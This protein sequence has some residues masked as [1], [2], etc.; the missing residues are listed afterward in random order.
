MNKRFWVLPFVCMIS[1]GI[2][3][4]FLFVTGSAQASITR[5][6]ESILEIPPT[7]TTPE[8]TTTI[9]EKLHGIR[10]LEPLA[11]TVGGDWDG[12]RVDHPRVITDTGGYRMWY[13]GRNPENPGYGWMVGLADSPDGLSWTKYAGNPLFGVGDPGEWDEMYR[14]QAAYLKEGGT[15]KMWFSG[16]ND[17]HWQT[18]YATSADGL[19]WSFYGS[20]P[21]LP[22]GP[23][24]TWDEGESD[25]PSVILEGGTYK[26][27]YHGCNADFSACNVGY[28]TSTDGID[29]NKVSEN[30]VLVPGEAG[31]WDQGW[32]A[33]PRV[34]KNGS[35][36]MMWYFSNDQ[37]GLAT[38]LDG[39]D[40]TKYSGNPVLSEGWDGAPIR[41]HD[42]MLENGTYKMWFRSGAGASE[43]IGYADSLDGITWNIHPDNPILSS[44]EAGVRIDVNYSHDWVQAFSRAGEAITV[45]VADGDGVK[46]LQVGV[47]GEWGDYGTW[48]Q[49]WNPQNP[50]LL[51]G[52]RITVEVAAATTTV[53]PIG[54]IDA[55]VDAETDTVSGTLHAPWFDPEG[56]TVLC[57]VWVENGPPGIEV[58]DV[59]PDGG[60]FSCDFGSQGW[61]ITPEQDIAVRYYEPDGDSVIGMFSA[62]WMRVNYGHDWVGGT[63]PA[64]H[65]FWITVTNDI[66]EVK[67]TAVVQSVPGGSWGGVDGFETTGGDWQPAQ[68]DIQPGDWVYFTS[69]DGYTNTIHVGQISTLVDADTDIVSGNLSADWLMPTPL[70]VRCEVWVPNGPPGIEVLDVSPDGGGFTCDFASVGWDVLP[71]QDIAVIYYEPDGDRVI[72][73][74]GAPWMRVNYGHDWAGGNY[75]AGHTVWITV[76]NDTGDIKATAEVLSYPG[77]GWG[78]D[79]FDT[80]WQDWAPS[81]PDI[82][83]G[84]WVYFT[85][86]DGYSNAIHVG[87][88]TG[89]VDVDTDS[90]SG[91]VFADWF[92]TTLAVECHPWGGPPGTPGKNSSAAADGTA[93]YFCQ[94]DPV[95]EWDILAGQDIGVMYI[96]P[97]GD[98][99][100]NPM[101]APAPYLRVNT[102]VDGNPAEGGNMDFYIEYRNEGEAIAENTVITATLQGMSYLGDTAPPGGILTGTLPNAEYVV[103]NLG[104]L[105]PDG[106]NH[107]FRL[108]TQVT[109][110]VSSTITSTVQI[111]TSTVYGDWDAGSK[112]GQ[113]SG[114]VGYNDTH[115]NVGKGAWTGDPTPGTDF[116]WAVN[117]C[118]N[119]STSSAGL[120][121]TDTLPISTTLVHWW[122]QHPGWV[123]VLK[124]DHNLVV[125][126]PSL[127]AGQCSEV[128]LQVHLDE[129][130]PI[131]AALVNTATIAS[132][133]DLETDDNQTTNT[134][135]VGPP[136]TNLEI[137]MDWNWGTL[138]PGGEIRYNIDY[139]NNGN[140]PVPGP[141]YITET[142]PAHTS[143]DSSWRNDESGQYPII[144]VEVTGE[145]VVWQIDGLENGFG[146]NFEVVLNI[147]GDALPG[148]QLVNRVE[149]TSLPDEDRYDDNTSEWTESVFE[150]GPNLRVRKVGDW[151][152]HGE[153]HNA[154]FNLIFENVGDTWLEQAT[155]TDTLPT[156]MI[157]DGDPSTDWGRVTNY[158]S[159]P[160]EGWFSI[161]FR[162]IHPNFRR[163]INFNTSI[164]GSDPLPYGQLFT[165]TAEAMLLPDDTNPDD[166]HGEVTLGTGPDLYVEKNLVAGDL[167]P[168]EVVTFGLRFGNRQPGHAWWWSLQGNAWMTDTL[169][170]G[171]EFISSQQRF[172]GWSNWCD[173]TPAQNGDLLTWQLWPIKAG[174]WNEIYLTV[175]IP[176]TADGRDTFTNWAEIASDLPDIDID[177]NEEDNASAYTWDILLP[178]FEV[179]K[180][181]ESS[182]IAGMPITYTLRVDNWGHRFGSNLTLI[183][184]LPDWMTYGGGGDAYNAGLITWD[185]PSLLSGSFTHE[186]F[187]GTLACTAGGLVNN[188][189]YRVSDSDQGV[190]SEYGPPVSFTILAPTIHPS[191]DTSHTTV[192]VGETVEFTST[193]TTDGTALSY[194]WDFGDGHIAVGDSASHAFDHPGRF[195]VTMTV[196]DGCGFSDTYDVEVT[197]NQK[198]FLPVVVR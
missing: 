109:E 100:L 31:E 87:E 127:S 114:H 50:N 158:T 67:A 37:I 107:R 136:H 41:G 174:E 66:D 132:A 103:W 129:S 198:V 185:I 120:T 144:P 68:P 78:T 63:Y 184:W 59:D 69:D 79:G 11:P 35:T 7:P 90:V 83:P 115:L 176:D 196:T 2:I 140:L 162:D 80:Q 19:A 157:L 134:V 122:E 108:F 34:I 113:W 10:T 42:V 110:P 4:L 183:D 53:D 96:E 178:Y 104:N 149:I 193:S 133:N 169:P 52:D 155:V 123:E 146:E 55:I 131:G 13:S 3:A 89:D 6:S 179:S 91:L 76:T 72:G 9:T 29:W 81:Q 18:G 171:F 121:L 165:N 161:T 98:R 145:V 194:A 38:S 82:Q 39:I 101:H 25:G 54:Q 141:F 84:D 181:Y 130:T 187:Y 75:P 46:A 170:A 172:C 28:A 151:H 15:Y 74:F 21:V 188:E 8:Q 30:P 139:H 180:E 36:Y 58:S 60:S 95:G 70:K 189:Y 23:S 173:N 61:D 164:P 195:T 138:V 85:T 102:W 175:R 106:I 17:Q 99:V 137:H 71:G 166:N 192:F 159:N 48:Q 190:A 117:T 186:E 143:F 5:V 112:E 20:N 197:V 24:G 51:P 47:V 1:F 16:G 88:I 191:F 182:R 27:W 93:P 126:R 97:D 118:N 105:P 45:T 73:V 12:Y 92:S 56:L 154:W 22:S 43:G 152:G 150:H 32:I 65:T 160:A 119:G 77:W 116:V 14:G 40:W 142:L 49:D 167:L 135:W 44:G 64:G 125:E 168:G 156:S 163:D 148:T 86:D 147:D 177:L 33:W 26:M 153:G 124:D 128:Y 57:E 94:W 111:G 62:P